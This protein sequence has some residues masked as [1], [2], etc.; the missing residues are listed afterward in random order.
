MEEAPWT[1]M[2]T[3]EIAT[4]LHIH[5]TYFMSPE[6]A[7]DFYAG[8]STA[9]K[10]SLGF[11]HTHGNY[12]GK[13]GDYVPFGSDANYRDFRGTHPLNYNEDNEVFK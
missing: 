11:L 13:G 4:F 10:R 9:I 1:D 12:D 2:G 3:E 5:P 6:Q 8:V 7:S